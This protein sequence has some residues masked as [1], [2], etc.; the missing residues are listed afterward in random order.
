MSTSQVEYIPQIG[1]LVSI[2]EQDRHLVSMNP[3]IY[4]FIY[5]N[6]PRLYYKHP[7]VLELDDTIGDIRSTFLDAQKAIVMHLLSEYYSQ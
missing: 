2:E 7:Y 4:H 3:N 1:Y 6:G 5:S